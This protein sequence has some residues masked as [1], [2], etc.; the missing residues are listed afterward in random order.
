M[1]SVDPDA[2]LAL[3]FPK[4]PDIIHPHR[5]VVDSELERL[6]HK[7]TIRKQGELRIFHQAV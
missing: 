5:L 1:L 2:V 6:V 7:A 4:Y 3:K